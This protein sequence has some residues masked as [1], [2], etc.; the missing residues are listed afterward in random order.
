MAISSEP[1][2]EGSQDAVDLLNTLH[3]PHNLTRDEISGDQHVI[4]Q[5]D[6]W[7]TNALAALKDLRRLLENKPDEV[8]QSDLIYT[9]AAFQGD[10][11]WTSEDIRALTSGKR[12]I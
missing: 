5:L 9:C 10:G 12:S 2:H 8:Q 7:K 11:D 1:V 4:A 6:E 3:I